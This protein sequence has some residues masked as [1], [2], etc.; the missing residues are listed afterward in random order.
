MAFVHEHEI[1]TRENFIISQGLPDIPYF[2]YAEQQQ[3]I[4][5]NGGQW[6]GRSFCGSNPNYPDGNCTFNALEQIQNSRALQNIPLLIPKKQNNQS[7]SF[8]QLKALAMQNIQVKE[9]KSENYTNFRGST[10]FNPNV[11]YYDYNAVGSLR[12]D[13]KTITYYERYLQ[14]QEKPSKKP[15][16]VFAKVTEEVTV[17]AEPGVTLD[18]IVSGITQAVTVQEAAAEEE[19]KTKWYMVTFPS[20]KIEERKVSQKFIDTMSARGW[21][22]EPIIDEPPPEQKE[23]WWVI[24]PSGIIEQVRVTQKFVDT[25]SARGWK[26]SKEK[27]AELEPINADISV[28]FSSGTG[29]DL[30]TH[31]N[32]S[33]LIIDKNIQH[34]LATWIMQ[35]YGT[36]IFLVTNRLTDNPVTHN[37]QSIKD[38]IKQKIL[39]DKPEE[40]DPEPDLTTSTSMVTQKLDYFDIIE[41]RAN[42]QITFRATSD[43]NPYYYG[44]ELV[45]YLQLVNKQGI[46]IA[47]KKANV[48]RF[49]QTE[50]DETIHYDEA[51]GDL[52]IVYATSTVET[53][54][55]RPM[56]ENYPFKIKKDAPPEEEEL[57]RTDFLAKIGGVLAGSIAIALL[58]PK[59]IGN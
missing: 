20:G 2:T 52:E 36:T 23:T 26:F 33:S 49:T 53:H 9:K 22:F 45:T 34:E 27:P 39:D 30:K 32:F 7:W 28:I 46:V 44:K 37:L 48:L 8:I 10:T 56:A 35:N 16:S 17:E 18:S 29:G 47:E 1:P 51:V 58:L 42:G 4:K 43:F 41:G 38:L 59:R 11:V 24:R 13:D 15:P 55:K 25:M 21:K 6:D 31:F 50:Q 19:F 57:P 5:T 54:D 12:Q 3:F 14:E 40:P